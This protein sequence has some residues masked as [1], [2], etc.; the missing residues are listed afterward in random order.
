[1]NDNKKKKEIPC[2]NTLQRIMWDD[3]MNVV[4]GNECTGLV[5]F[6]PIDMDEAEAYADIYSVPAM[7]SDA[8]GEPSD[9]IHT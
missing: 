4:S 9:Y 6:M 7:D 8:E 2:A 3:M 5:P 1:M